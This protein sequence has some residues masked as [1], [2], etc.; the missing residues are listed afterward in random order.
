MTEGQHHLNCLTEAFSALL[1]VTAESDVDRIRA[2][3][4][5]VAAKIGFKLDSLFALRAAS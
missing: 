1:S 2:S 3:V 4:A 5:V